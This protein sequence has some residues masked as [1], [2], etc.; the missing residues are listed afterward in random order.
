M[1]MRRLTLA[2]ILP[3]LVLAAA[4]PLPGRAS[5]PAPQCPVVRVS[6]PDAVRSGGEV[7][8][9]AEVVGAGA[10]F[11]PTF[12]WQ[13]SAG[14]IVSGQGTA[15]LRV[16]STG[17]GQHVVT[18]TVEVAG[19]SPVCER[20]ASCSTPVVSDIIGCG[21]DEYGNIKFDDEKARLDNFA[22]ELQNDP[23]AQGHMI[24]YGG[25][26]GYKGEAMRRCERAKGYLSDVRGIEAARVVTVDGGFREELTVKLTIVPSG[27]TPPAPTPTVDLS[28][29]EFIKPPTKRGARRN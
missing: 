11:K 26:R 4:S 18:A 5:L 15:L 19:L 3:L 14:S 12:E 23:T 22:I 21:F 29:V 25:R 16:D 28:E 9:S 2:T 27:A 8:F 24:C 6:C 10:T 13:V 17:L 7:N 1:L 20:K